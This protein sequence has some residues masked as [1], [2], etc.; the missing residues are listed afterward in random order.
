MAQRNNEN[1]DWLSSFREGDPRSFQYLFTRYNK[2]LLYNAEL[3][4]RD[5]QEAEDIVS[6][7]FRKAWEN[8]SGF[9]NTDHVTGFLYTTTRN[10]CLNRV[11]HIQRKESSHKELSYLSL[12][13]EEDF[14]KRMIEAELLDRIYGEIEKLPKK[15]RLVFKLIY[16]EGYSTKET[17]LELKIS[18][19]NVLNQK[20]RAIQLLKRNLL[21]QVLI[22]LYISKITPL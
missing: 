7:T 11:K 5:K 6:D 10:A 21:V 17:A 16:L 15:C 2:R 8:H 9:E 14:L 13:K 12:D 18:E 22:W 3:I 4:L 1:E 19:R 20:S